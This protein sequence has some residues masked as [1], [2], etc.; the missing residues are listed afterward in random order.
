MK[1]LFIGDLDSTFV[2]R[3]FDMLS[4]HNEIIALAPPKSKS[5]WPKYIA[6]IKRIMEEVP[7]AFGWFAG[8]H[9]APMVHYAK[10]YKKSSIVVLGGYDAVSFPEINYGA[11][12]NVKERVPAKFVIINAD[13]ILPVSKYLAREA[14]KNTGIKS[15]KIFSIP[16]G[17]DFNFWKMGEKKENIVLTVAGANNL[18]RVKVKGLDTFVKAAK[19]VPEADFVVIGVEG[20]ARK[21]L[22]SIAPSNV[23]LIG[24]TPNSK[25]LPYY[26][27]ARV[28][29]Q[30]SISEGLPNT[31]CEAMLSG[32][33]PVGTKRGGIP[34][35][36]GNI[37]FYVPYGDAKATAEAIKK[38][39]NASEERGIKAR[40]RIIKLFPEREREMNLLRVISIAPLIKY[41]SMLKRKDTVEINLNS[42]E[43]EYLEITINI[44]KS[45]SLV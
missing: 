18:R 19:F 15:E 9:T 20:E 33:I 12:S 36:M 32:D 28:Y 35:V 17:Y 44:K 22:K 29:A 27:K 8:W 39:L 1:I 6:R 42:S 23:Q 26:Q 5:E 40:E 31:L 4:K 2:K 7:V 37:G 43:R 34:E 21:Y 41:S 13:I 45:S 14:M 16:T 30:L 3:D 11:F 24:Y 25:L 10:K 38:A